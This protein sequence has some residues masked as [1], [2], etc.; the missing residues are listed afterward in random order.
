MDGPLP[1]RAFAPL[2]EMNE[3]TLHVAA[4]LPCA[5]SRMDYRI[6]VYN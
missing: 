6:Y 4:P 3:A 5:A 2:D 1:H